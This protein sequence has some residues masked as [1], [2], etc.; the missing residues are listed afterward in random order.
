[1]IRKNESKSHP[2]LNVEPLPSLA[3]DEKGG[4][5]GGDHAK[6]ETEGAT[7]VQLVGILT[8]QAAPAK[9]STAK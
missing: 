2:Y 6:K 5:A 3:P 9:V 7:L 4:N 8:H 1:M